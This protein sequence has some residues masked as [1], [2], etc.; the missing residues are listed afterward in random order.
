[1]EFSAIGA[2]VIDVDGVLTDGRLWYDLSGDTSASRPGE[3]TKAFHVQDGVAIKLWRE[4]GGRV[5]ILS[6]RV[7]A[8]VAVRGRELGIEVI[9]QGI[10][11][12]LAAFEG[13]CAE[14]SLDPRQVAYIG[15]DLPDIAPLHRCGLPIA[16]ANAVPGVKRVAQLITRR[17]GGDGAVQE[18][19][20]WLRRKQRRGKDTADVASPAEIGD[21]PPSAAG[22]LRTDLTSGIPS[23]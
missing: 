14:W 16:P 8:A 13:V 10:E 9:L 23:G 15:D 3:G 21:P 19:I 18:A 22:G 20:E 4:A 2:L 6:G 1:M 11:D 17:R 7:A 5:A 12:K